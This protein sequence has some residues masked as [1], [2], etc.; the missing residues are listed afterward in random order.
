MK[1]QLQYFKE[2]PS[3]N[4]LALELAGK[5]AGEGLVII[6][7]HQTNGRGKPGR[8]WISPAGKDLLFSVLLRPRVPPHRAPLLTQIAC[9]AV[10]KVLKGCKITSTFKRPNDI[11]VQGKKI[12]GVLVEASSGSKGKLESAV[13]G[14]GLNVNASLKE[15]VPQ[16]TSMKEITGREYSRQNLLK[17]I[18]RELRNDLKEFYG[19][20][21]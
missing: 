17:Q 14:I 16:A 21:S 18:L 3:T 10:A 13:V 7:D 19:Y 2:L 15:L 6:A 8:K 12:C 5:G 11:L 1:F 4:T 20:P 9:R